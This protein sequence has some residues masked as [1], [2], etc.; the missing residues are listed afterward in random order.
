MHIKGGESRMNEERVGTSLVVQW[1]RP[2]AFTAEDAGSIPSWGMKILY[3]VE[4]SQKLKQIL[5]KIM[6]KCT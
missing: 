6:V 2:Y 5:L 1:L 4:C 3:A